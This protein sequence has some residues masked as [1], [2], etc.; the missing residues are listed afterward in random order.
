MLS[1]QAYLKVKV[2]P[3]LIQ[4][5]EQTVSKQR[6]MMMDSHLWAVSNHFLLDGM[7]LQQK[8]SQFKHI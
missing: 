8:G 1:T 6:C 3:Q 4:I 2:V 7:N 5:V